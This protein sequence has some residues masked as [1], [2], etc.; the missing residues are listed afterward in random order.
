MNYRSVL[1]QFIQENP[2]D[3]EARLTNE[4][5]LKIKREGDLAIFNYGVGAHFSDPIVQEARGIILDVST[6]EVVCWPFRKFGNH[7]ESYADSIDWESARVLEKV[8][9]SIVK[10]WFDHKGGKWQ[11]STN[12]TIR[13]E[14]APVDGAFGLTFGKVIMSAENYAEIPFDSL[15]KHTTYI[16]ELVS[17]ET[18]VVVRYQTPSLY[19][20]GTRHNITGLESDCDIG[21]KKPASYPLTSLSECIHAAARLNRDEDAPTDDIRQE[22]FVVV[23]K[24]YHRVKVK[25]PDYLMMHRLHQVGTLSKKD[26]LSL[27]LT[28]SPNIQPLCDANP[29]LVPLFKF[30]EYHLS[31]LIYLADRIAALSRHL[32]EEYSR[33]RGAVARVIARHRLSAIGFLALDGE[34]SGKDILLS[35]SV[36]KLAKFIPDYLPEDLSSLFTSPQ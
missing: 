9:G 2:E 26:A 19:H 1:C 30:Y 25:S 34:K 8:D 15:D 28:Q 13:A 31:E 5:T 3:W 17:P 23:D 27:I 6:L 12:A 4:Y 33:D 14:E 24:A 22:G 16:F 7:N 10:L 29:H 36:E 35:L 18:T 21:I 32:Y 11:F 20:I